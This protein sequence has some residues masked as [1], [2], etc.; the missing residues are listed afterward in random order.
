[1]DEPLSGQ[2]L[3]DQLVVSALL[4][5]TDCAVAFLTGEGR[6]TRCNAG[7]TELAGLP[8][9]TTGLSLGTMLPAPVAAERLMWLVRAREWNTPIA[10]DGVVW[11]RMLRSMMR[12]LEPDDSGER[13]V[14][15]TFSPSAGRP[16]PP[17]GVRVIRAENDDLGRMA[18]LTDREREVL[19]LIGMGLST[20]EIADRLFRAAK[21]IEGHRVSL[22]V[23]LGVSNRVQLA[24]IAIRAGL[25]PLSASQ[26]EIKPNP[27]PVT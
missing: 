11:G 20:A 7:F 13:L 4:H 22:G 10:L 18:A 8:E 26:I 19:A 24:R 5:D 12:P 1:M 2:D 25:S 27:R 9:G 17:E 21:T 23:K 6:I 15:M 14:L 3:L 16:P